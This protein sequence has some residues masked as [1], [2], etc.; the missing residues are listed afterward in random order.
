MTIT[1]ILNARHIDFH[2]SKTDEW[3]IALKKALC[4]A[5]FFTA[6]NSILTHQ[7][8]RT[9]SSD[10]ID[11]IISSLAIYNNIQNLYLNMIFL[12]TIQPFFSTFQLTLTNLFRFQLLYHE[13]NW[14]SI[15]SSV[16]KQ[17]AILQD[18]T[19]HLI[20]PENPDPIN[21]IYSAAN[22]QNKHQHSTYHSTSHQTKKK[23][24]KAF[25]KSRNS[26]L[27]SVLNAISKKIK[28]KKK[29][30]QNNKTNKEQSECIF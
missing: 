14:D 30:K 1:G 28:K 15:N 27:K 25:I 7:D 5:D 9:N 29:T 17:I 23:I 13:A 22:H 4:N 21:I 6:E 10:I 18:R 26:F 2:C 24:K 12:Q 11:Y 8:R 19:S 20:S 3:G 16:S